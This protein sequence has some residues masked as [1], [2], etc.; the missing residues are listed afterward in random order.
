MMDFEARIRFAHRLTQERR[1]R[2]AAERLLDRKETELMAANVKLA[3]QERFLSDEIV[4]KQA[5]AQTFRTEAETLKGQNTRVRE[6]LERANHAILRAERRLWEALETIQDGF[7]VFDTKRRLVTANR[8]YLELF[9][10]FDEIAPGSQY[11]DIM[12]AGAEEGMFDIGDEA[13]ADWCFRFFS[14]WDDDPIEPVTLKLW[15]ETY[16]KLVE[17]IGIGGDTV[18]LAINITEMMQYQAELEE[19]QIRAEAASRAKSAFL[20]NMSHE[21]RTPMNGVIGMADL[22]NETD[23]DEE[24][25]SYVET[26]RN[27][28]E[29][30]LVIINDVLDYSKIEA[31]KLK[32]YPEP[33]DLERSIHEVLMLLRPSVQDKPVDML[34]DYDLFLPTSYVGDPGRIRQI[35]TNLLGNAAKFTAEGHVVVRVVGI[36]TA[37]H[38]EVR[39]HISVEDTGIGIAP[40]K[41]A[42]V[43]GQF[44]QVD[45]QKNRKFEGTGLGLAITRQLIEL[46]DGEV[47]VDSVEGEGSVFGFHITLPVA[48]DTELLELT[49]PPKLKKIIVVDDLAINRTILER[50][51]G[52]LGVEVQSFESGK[53]VLAADVAD[54]DLILTDH[55]M[56]GMNGIELTKALRD[57]GFTAPILLL[58]SNPPTARADPGYEHVTAILQK[59]VLRRELFRTLER[60]GAEVPLG[61]PGP[62]VADPAP[63]GQRRMR[64]LAAEDNK[65]NRLVLKKMLKSLDIDLEFATDGLEAV[66]AFES[67][68]P[69]F[70]FMD[71]SMPEMDGKEATQ[72]IRAIEEENSWPRTPICALTA[73]AMTGDDEGILKAGLDYYLTKPLKKAQLHEKLLGHVPEGTLPLLSDAA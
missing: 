71:I 30:L 61:Q 48:E 53:S 44:N 51:L 22:I 15:N 70:I 50:Q 69:D 5:E 24:Q 49:L 40:D 26:I 73:H 34:V 19:A 2:L 57:S 68:R 3:D 17:R 55:V 11:E 56:D 36:E 65:T 4:I 43:F 46:M 54:A 62:A 8:A 42:H 45:D 72:R 23:L 25:R 12:K 63:T 33:F 9:E 14:R 35:L 28:G 41:V 60:L 7:A 31:E 6:D 29:A 59:P 18:T 27:S 39:L 67:Q 58:T 52:A 32:L 16:V 1:A 64:V 21:I 10:G 37:N 47:W 38:G 20:A 13:P 66:A